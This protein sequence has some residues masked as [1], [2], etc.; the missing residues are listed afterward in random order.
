VKYD[1]FWTSFTKIESR[2]SVARGIRQAIWNTSTFGKMKNIFYSMPFV[3]GVNVDDVRKELTEYTKQHFD[4]EA[5]ARKLNIPI[6]TVIRKYSTY[7][8][9]YD[10]IIKTEKEMK[11]DDFFRNESI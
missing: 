4:N 3:R 2:Q 5:I 11:E 8:K 6:A 10:S 1:L 7:K 9:I